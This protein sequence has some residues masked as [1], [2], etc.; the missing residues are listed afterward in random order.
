MPAQKALLL[1]LNS[2]WISPSSGS[3][4]L[5]QGSEW[6]LSGVFIRAITITFGLFACNKGLNNRSKNDPAIYGYA[7]LHGRLLR[8]RSF[9]GSLLG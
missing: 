5:T 7:P 6:F 4:Y 2:H 1:I 8:L 9:L 3:E